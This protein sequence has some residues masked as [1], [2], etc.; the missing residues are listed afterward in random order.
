MDLGKDK[1]M[2]HKISSVLIV[3][4]ACMVLAGCNPQA[5]LS[6]KFNQDDAAVYKVVSES[7]MNF[8]FAMPSNN[9]FSEKLT[10]TRVEMTFKQQIEN[11]DAQGVAI[12]NITIQDLKILQVKENDVKF[13]YDS[14]KEADKKLAPAGLIGQSYKISIDPTGKVKVVDAKKANASIK[15]SVAGVNIKGIV[16]DAAIIRRHEILSLSN[17]EKAN[18]AVGDT[19]STQEKPPY[20]ILSSKTY[21]KVYTLDEI[22]SDDDSK[23]AYVSMNA[24][25]AGSAEGNPVTMMAGMAPGLSMDSEDSYK[26]SMTFDVDSGIVLTHGQV[27]EVSTIATDTRAK[28]KDPDVLTITQTFTENAEIVK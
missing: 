13:D 12:A 27:L 20:K 5:E 11:V 24:I 2:S 23:I 19:W 10:K 4:C 21:E 8:K 9:K 7:T 22:K 26:G 6:L 1:D 17:M 3:A 25:P 18:V 15:R 16:S 14:Q 28:D